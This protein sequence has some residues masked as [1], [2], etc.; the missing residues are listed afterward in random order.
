MSAFELAFSLFGLL[1]GL[2]LAEVLAGFANCIQ[3]RQQVK[4][5]WLTP[6]LGLVV[7]LDLTSYWMLAWT[8]REIIPAGYYTLLFGLLLCGT[9]YLVARLVFPRDHKEWPDFDLYYFAHKKWTLGGVL[10]CNLMALAA[11]FA[12][13]GDPLGGWVNKGVNLA[14]Y[15]SLTA[16]L[17]ARGRMLNIVLLGLIAT[18]YFVF[19][20]LYLLFP[21]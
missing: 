8:S 16:A 9:Y 21:R 13:G 6:L 2:G 17:L 10:L 20:L 3:S 7:A 19:P 11:T 15:L 5:G 18:Q 4:V 1:L 14:Y 12:L